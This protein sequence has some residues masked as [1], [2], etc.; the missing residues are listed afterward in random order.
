[1]VMKLR[2]MNCEEN[3]VVVSN[4]M[5]DDLNNETQQKQRIKICLDTS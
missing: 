3:N 4:P 2:N 1:L 5:N